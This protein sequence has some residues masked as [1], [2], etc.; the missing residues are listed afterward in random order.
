MATA[1]VLLKY[2]ICMVVLGHFARNGCLKHAVFR[3]VRP[4]FFGSTGRKEHTPHDIHTDMPTYL[5]TYST[6]SS[7]SRGLV[8]C[9]AY[10]PVR[11]TYQYVIIVVLMV[12]ENPPLK[13]RMRGGVRWGT[14]RYD[15]ET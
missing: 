9:T 2:I 14:V 8:Y 11:N 15:E 3:S 1:S 5:P 4:A 10:L 7:S 12:L 6:I 13:A